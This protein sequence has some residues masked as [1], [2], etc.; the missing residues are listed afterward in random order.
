MKLPQAVEKPVNLFFWGSFALALLVVLT[1]LP[2][3]RGGFIWDDDAHLTENPCIIGPLGFSGIWTTP[4]AVYYPLVLTTFWVEHGI[5]GL[6][7]MP[8]HLVNV[9]AQAGCAI[10]FWQVLMA[11]RVR[12]AWLGAM[13]WALHPVQAESVAWITELKNTQSGF[14]Y[15][16][17]VLFFIKW[18]VPAAGM[19]RPNAYYAMA[20]VFSVMAI[21]SKA[22]TV[23]LPAVMGLCAWR[24]EGRWRWRNLLP[25]API[26][27]IAAL[28]SAWTIWEQQHHSGALGPEW[29]HTLA[30]RIVIS[31]KVI[32]FYLG[33][34][35]WPDPLIFIYPRWK[36]DATQPLA[37][38]PAEAAAVLWLAL[39][40][41]RNGWARPFFFAF[42]YFVVALFPV[43]G[44]FAVFFFRYSYVSDHFQY[45]ASM[46]P[47]ALAGSAI[48]TGVGC[49]KTAGLI[50]RPA[51]SGLLALTL[52]MLT[53][54]HA[55]LFRDQQ[56]LWTRTLV[57]NPEAAIGRVN[58]A[59]LAVDAGHPEEALAQSPIL[60]QAYPDDPTILNIVGSAH[61]E[62]S[63]YDDAIDFF[64]K[65]VALRAD[66]PKPW[67]NLGL[68]FL[69][70][71]QPSRAQLQFENVVKLDP[72]AVNAYIQLARIH[73][74]RQEDKAAIANLRQCLAVQPA[75]MEACDL[76]AWT[77]AT[78][79]DPAL[80]NG[81]EA[82]ELAL[83]ANNMTAGRR[84][85]LL[86]TLAAAF[87]ES[88]DFPHAI[89][90]LER[91]LTLL[92]AKTNSPL[93]ASCREQLTLYQSHRPY[94][95]S[96]PNTGAAP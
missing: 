1:Y 31:G 28:A 42:S 26:L 87:A 21:L 15:L 61:L 92:S 17:A 32:W 40:W 88:E 30:E 46:G 4:A 68:A 73:L 23:V 51:L 49:F 89:Q 66:N 52:A 74:A 94:H 3:L 58:L 19:K 29:Q 33:K 79:S 10:L 41:W 34:L 55:K 80:R 47:L 63:H 37:W 53:W 22:S 85:A 77:L 50:L 90:C 57:Q 86:R 93:A 16:L 27:F 54:Q 12:G 95:V 62:L 39:W 9:L 13:L 81:R 71:D 2:A 44:F 65:S 24:V 6:V 96:T 91:A 5:W 25:L 84:P 56:T 35:I 69:Q 72:T 60:L 78:S 67:Y 20:L 14:F 36:I 83:R 8:Y 59:A 70:K 64:Q 43:L 7:P 48:V 76:L 45:L 82:V 11:L 38:L 18:R 75:D